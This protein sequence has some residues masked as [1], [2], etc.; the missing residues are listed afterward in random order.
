MKVKLKVKAAPRSSAGNDIIHIHEMD[1]EYFNVNRVCKISVGKKSV[2]ATV[3]GNK[4]L[5]EIQIDTQLR[6]RLDVDINKDYEFLIDYKFYYFF[7][8]PFS[9]T[10]MGVRAA[11]FIAIISILISLL[12]ILIP[13]L[14]DLLKLLT[15]CI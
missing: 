12:P 7:I 6:L 2:Y 4:D 1:R 10:N 5:H 15:K 13:N 14:F 3:R 11:Y 9:A 8:A